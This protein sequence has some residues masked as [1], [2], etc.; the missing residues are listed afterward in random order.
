MVPGAGGTA[1]VQQQRT[2][3]VALPQIGGTLGPMVQGRSSGAPPSYEQ[4]L[5]DPR[6]VTQQR[7]GQVPEGLS[8]DQRGL[9]QYLEL[10]AGGRPVGAATQMAD[11]DGQ[12]VQARRELYTPSPM[13]DA[14]QGEPSTVPSQ[15]P[16]T[17]GHGEDCIHQRMAMVVGATQ[18]RLQEMERFQRDILLRLQQAEHQRQ[19][20]EQEAQQSRIRLE[21]HLEAHQ[22]SV[23]AG[24]AEEALQR[25]GGGGQDG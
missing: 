15:A 3:H 5:R 16:S 24:L 10:G 22:R 17:D 7:G 11:G 19:C 12:F 8:E 4:A 23:S 21:A 9:S 18:L 6:W 14:C 25:E 2:G 1:A 20:A 13:P